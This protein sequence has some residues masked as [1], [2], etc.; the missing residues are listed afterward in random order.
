[1]HDKP[2][3]KDSW[4]TGN[5]WKFMWPFKIKYEKFAKYIVT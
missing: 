4:Y 3:S 1:M 5:I 2:L